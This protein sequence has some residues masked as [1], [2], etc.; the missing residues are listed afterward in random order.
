LDRY[1]E[2]NLIIRNLMETAVDIGAIQSGLSNFHSDLDGYRNRQRLLFSELQ[3]KLMRVRMTPMSVISQR[4][5]R[6]VRETAAQLDKKVRLVIEGEHTE[7]DRMVWEKLSDPLMHLLR[8]AVDHGIAQPEQRGTAGKPESGRVRISASYEGQ[9][10]VIRV[11][12]DGA[13]IAYPSIREKVKQ[14]QLTPRTDRLSNDELAEYIFYPGF[15]TR[16][17]ISEISGRGVGLD[18]VKEAIIGLNGSVRIAPAESTQGTEFVIRLPL[19]VAVV[20]ALMISID[21]HSI[22]VPLGDVKEILRVTPEQ[23]TE[24]PEPSIKIGHELLPLHYLSSMFDPEKIV[25]W[26]DASTTSFTTLIVDNGEWRGAVVVD[27][28]LGQKEIVVKHL[29]SHLG[30]VRGVAGATIMGAG[31][32]VP[33]I[34]VF[35]LFRSTSASNADIP[36]ELE[37]DFGADIDGDRLD[38]LI[39]DDSVSIRQVVSR[40][41]RQQGWQVRTSRDGIEALEEV[42]RSRPDVVILDIEMPRMNGYEF[43]AAFRRLP[44]CKNTPVIMLTSRTGEK[45]RQKAE[46]SGASGYVV[47]PYNDD[48]FIALVKR[49]THGL[50]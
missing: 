50:N 34:N 44:D 3:D 19:T 7:L 32:V 15:S 9:Q 25:P 4:L 18:V 10:V 28:L 26:K 21:N 45:H 22:A 33:I 30:T 6:T 41:M 47:K 24:Q 48:E 14:L 49:L 42:H 1:S 11:T 29:G 36:K 40:L 27:R 23:C 13:G 2:F 5:R 35:E 31:T 8:N 20:R 12:D 39:V 17:N 38:I 37:A 43:L 16:Q 46:T